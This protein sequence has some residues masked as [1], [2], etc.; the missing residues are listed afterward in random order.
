MRPLGIYVIFDA[1]RVTH[2]CEGAQLA[3]QISPQRAYRRFG[4]GQWTEAETFAEYWN[5]EH[6]HW[7]D[8]YLHQGIKRLSPPPPPPPRRGVLSSGRALH[9]LA[10]FTLSTGLSAFLAST[11]ARALG[12]LSAFVCETGLAFT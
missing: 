5:Y 9:T 2:I 3:R 8:V 7:T 6:P 4:P 12:E 10:S 1:G 11:F